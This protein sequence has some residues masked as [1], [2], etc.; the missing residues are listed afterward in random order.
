MPISLGFSRELATLSHL[1]SGDHV[2]LGRIGEEYAR[3]ALEAH[4]YLVGTSRERRH[5]DLWVSCPSGR[6]LCVEVKTAR[7]GK[8]GT[9]Q[10]CIK[11]KYNNGAIKTDCSKCDAVMLLAVRLSGN[12]EFFIIPSKAIQYTHIIKIGAFL[13]GSKSKYLIYRQQ[14][15]RL[16]FDKIEGLAREME[17]KPRNEVYA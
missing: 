11:R 13:K 6:H 12:V 5:G 7:I 1:M 17:D 4:G 3:I 15:G 9:W 14:I 2:S 8:D 16:N 10:F